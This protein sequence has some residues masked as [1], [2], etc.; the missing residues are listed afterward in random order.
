MICF[1]E[2]TFARCLLTGDRRRKCLG[3]GTKGIYVC[4][5]TKELCM[6]EEVQV[7]HYSGSLSLR[8]VYHGVHIYQNTLNCT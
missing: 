2:F 7:D 5:S 3:Q 8:V 4:R 1:P 6:F